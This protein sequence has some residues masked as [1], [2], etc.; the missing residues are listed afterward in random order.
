MSP[1]DFPHEGTT[2]EKWK[3][4]LQYAVLAPSSHNTQPWLFHVRGNDLELYADRTRSCHIVDPDGRELI[5]SC[6]CAL[7]HLRSAMAHF[8]YF[9]GVTVLPDSNDPDLL[10]RVCLGIQEE[11]SPE[12]SILFYMKI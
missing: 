4:L 3:F 6:G 2:F 12:E 5:M 8:G 11:N 10:A 9:G 7:F 1:E